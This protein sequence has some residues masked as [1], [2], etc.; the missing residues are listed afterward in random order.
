MLH[1]CLQHLRVKIGPSVRMNDG[2]FV[3][4]SMFRQVC[5]HLH[6]PMW[7]SIQRKI[8]LFDDS[9]FLLYK[10]FITL[11]RRLLL[12]VMLFP[13]FS[14]YLVLWVRWFLQSYIC[15][16]FNFANMQPNQRE[17]QRALMFKGKIHID[18]LWKKPMRFTLGK[19]PISMHSKTE[20]FHKLD[21]VTKEN[22]KNFCWKKMIKYVCGKLQGQF[23]AGSE[24]RSK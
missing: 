22:Y 16:S 8:K 18:A 19:N 15:F 20:Y 3:F 24:G 21:F 23:V 6:M 17:L 4:S 10:E 2:A 1:E 7:C 12:I 13:P 11:L 9:K 5:W 14:H